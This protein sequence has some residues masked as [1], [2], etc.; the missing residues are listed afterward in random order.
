MYNVSFAAMAGAAGG[1]A[2][3]AASTG[4]RLGSSH[5]MA[6]PGGVAAGGGERGAGPAGGGGG[7]VGAGH[8]RSKLSWH[9][10]ATM[11][12]MGSG[13][14]AVG[15]GGGLHHLRGRHH[16]SSSADN[17]TSFFSKLDI[18][19]SKVGGDAWYNKII[20]IIF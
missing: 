10:D 1:D 15:A 13:G 16:H 5:G 3:E 18:L 20:N 4:G 19:A 11:V 9:A 8:H 7:G 6:G 17:A 2:W 14:A 12:S